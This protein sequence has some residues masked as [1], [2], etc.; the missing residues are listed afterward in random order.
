[1]RTPQLTSKPIHASTCRPS[2]VNELLCAPNCLSNTTKRDEGPIRKQPQGMDLD[3]ASETN[4]AGDRIEPL[5]CLANRLPKKIK[6]P[7]ACSQRETAVPKHRPHPWRHHDREANWRDP[8]E[9]SRAPNHA[10]TPLTEPSRCWAQCQPEPFCA[11]PYRALPARLLP[12]H[13]SQHRPQIP[14]LEPGSPALQDTS[15]STTRRGPT[16]CAS[17]P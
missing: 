10:A 16:S 11:P 13:Q 12:Q 6:S 2:G 14:L 1:M 7:V 8:A 9:S 3:R 15:P 5:S 17:W 4:L